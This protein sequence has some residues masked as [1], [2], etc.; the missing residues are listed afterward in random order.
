MDAFSDEFQGLYKFT[1]SGALVSLRNSPDQLAGVPQDH[2]INAPP[3][4]QGLRGHWV[5]VSQ[6]ETGRDTL[7]LGRGPVAGLFLV[8]CRRLLRGG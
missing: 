6:S 1:A 5:F 7:R 2:L 4:P 3:S 8:P